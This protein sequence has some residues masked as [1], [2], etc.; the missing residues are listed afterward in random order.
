ML[1]VTGLLSL[2]AAPAFA[3]QGTIDHVQSTRGSLQVLYSLPDSN[4]LKPDLGSVAVTLN[5]KPLG[6]SA[7]LA[8]TGGN[9]I[10]RSTVLAIDV[11]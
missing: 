8:S 6:A 4:G 2:V 1:M 11:S 3:A 5:G 10:R 9:S 7:A